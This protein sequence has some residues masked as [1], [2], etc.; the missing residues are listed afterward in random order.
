MP[1][2]TQTITRYLVGPAAPDGRPLDFRCLQYGAAVIVDQAWCVLAAT[3][4]EA[5]ARATASVGQRWPVVAIVEVELEVHVK[6]IESTAMVADK[7]IGTFT[8][9]AV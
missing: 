1:R 6:H 3:L 9:A 5:R 8:P 7:L 4:E 2:T